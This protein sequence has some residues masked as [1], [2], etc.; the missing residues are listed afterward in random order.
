M[1]RYNIPVF[2]LNLMRY[3]SNN[4]VSIRQSV[5]H[6]CFLCKCKNGKKDNQSINRGEIRRGSIDRSHVLFVSSFM[7]EYMRNCEEIHTYVYVC[8]SVCMEGLSL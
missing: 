4:Y 3:V 5:N 2:V 6:T 7:C 1:V 8:S